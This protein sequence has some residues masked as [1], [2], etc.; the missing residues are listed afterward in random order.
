M[1]MRTVNNNATENDLVP[2]KRWKKIDRGEACQDHDDAENNIPPVVKS[3]IR[4]I[5]DLEK[6]RDR[7]ISEDVLKNYIN[8]AFRTATRRNLKSLVKFILESNYEFD[9]NSC[10]ENG[11]TS[12]LYACAYNHPE[13]V[14]ILVSQPGLNVNRCESQGYSPLMWACDLGYSECVKE[15]IKHP[16]IDINYKDEAGNTALI[17]AVDRGQL[18]VVKNILTH[19]NLDVNAKGAEGLTALIIASRNGVR[20][21]AEMLVMDNRTD[22]NSQDD[23]GNTAL[24]SAIELDKEEIVK[25]LLQQREI[26]IE[27]TDCNGV[28]PGALAQKWNGY[29]QRANR[30]ATLMR[31]AENK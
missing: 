3:F 12:I 25:L 26:D 30:I 10:N 24:H 28:T 7:W 18:E 6:L 17:W 16:N 31:Q 2:I 8:K 27:I 23:F 21:I 13:L 29:N 22:V 14:K 15:I 11:A 9:I 4:Q 19:P 1:E 5:E 20:D